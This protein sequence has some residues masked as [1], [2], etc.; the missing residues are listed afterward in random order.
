[1]P[2]DGEDWWRWEGKGK[3]KLLEIMNMFVILSLGI[4][5]CIHLSKLIKLYINIWN[6]LYIN[7]IAKISHTQYFFLLCMQLC[8]MEF[9]R[10]EIESKLQLWPMVQ[11]G[12][13]ATSV[14]LMHCVGLGIKPALLQRQCQIFNPLRHSGN[15]PQIPH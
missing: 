12:I 7:Y 5:S 10:P 4:A 14:S 6:L 9:P 2:G 1:M 13:L 15:S 11:P 3:R 8:H